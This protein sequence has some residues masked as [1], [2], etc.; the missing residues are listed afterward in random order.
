MTR[1]AV[2]DVHRAPETA[3]D[4]GNVIVGPERSGFVTTSEAGEYQRQ[5]VGQVSLTTNPCT[6]P[7]LSK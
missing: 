5:P 1:V 6:L 4:A 2:G 3:H 7:W